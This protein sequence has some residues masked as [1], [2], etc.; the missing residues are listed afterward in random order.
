MPRDFNNAFL[1]CDGGLQGFGY[2][3][4]NDPLGHISQAFQICIFSVTNP[5]L[6]NTKGEARLAKV[7]S[8]N[9]G[10]ISTSNLE[11]EFGYEHGLRNASRI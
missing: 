11:L 2:C 9:D 4:V 6:N 7:V 1:K 3:A 8:A 5:L 10:Q